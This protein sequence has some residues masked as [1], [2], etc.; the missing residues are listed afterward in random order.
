VQAIGPVTAELEVPDVAGHSLLL[1]LRRYDHLN[2][3]LIGEVTVG[4]NSTA[5]GTAMAR[6][7]ESGLAAIGQVALS[8][9]LPFSEDLLTS[10]P[11]TLR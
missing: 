10:A 9:F 4:V 3:Q 8:P 11:G 2:G 6:A 7:I 5:D 1:G